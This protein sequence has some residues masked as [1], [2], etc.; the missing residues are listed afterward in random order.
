M[1]ET[2]LNP[3][4]TDERCGLIL[5]DGSIVEI[6]NVADDKT[7]SYRMNPSAVLP[8]VQ[9][10][11][12]AGTW[13]THPGGTPNLSGADQDGFLSWPDLEHSIVGLRDGQVVVKRYR[14]VNGLIVTCA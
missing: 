11:M 1:L 8:F 12:V 4:D 2:L 9:N 6:E 13:H 3:G 14:I 7:D 10:D 5:K